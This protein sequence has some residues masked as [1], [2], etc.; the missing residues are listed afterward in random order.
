MRLYTGLKIFH[1]QNKLDS[2]PQDQPT[3]LPPIH[4]RIKPTNACNHNCSYC[5]YRADNL[6]L[7]QHMNIR[8]R[9]P[10]AK[11]A[12]IVEDCVALGVKAVT[13][14]GGGEPLC[15]PHIVK[16]ANALADGGVGIAT[17]TN[18]AL[19]QGAAADVF[20][21]RGVWVRL[22]MDGWDGPSYARYRNVPETEFARVMDNIEAFQK[23]GGPCFLGVSFIVGQD[24]ADHV[25]E[26][27]RRLKDAGVASLK[28]SPCV[29]SND[30]RENNA[31]H[32]PIFDKVK[33]QTARA[34]AELADEGF[35][36]FDSYHRLD[37][38]FTKSYSWC[39]YL[40]I[41]PVI[42]A[43]QRVYSCQDKAY[44]LDCG[45]LGSIRDRRFADFWR[46][47]K[48]KFFAINPAR[49]CNHH[50]VANGKNRL[51]HE[52]LDADPR[53]LPFV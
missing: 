43:D 34:A 25:F 13:F 41:L 53:H 28:Y 8:D 10:E 22:S 19:L 50:C 15:Y 44:N 39:P 51:V 37:E 18:G 52:Y 9:I 30:G 48:D 45:L 2:L 20:A 12:E 36:I 24:N 23:R 17:L 7:G 35:E 1:Y 31:Y 14:S 42:A 11:M 49:D 38:K 16:T 4:I 3:I 33:E 40:Q 47:G 5:A 6:Q 26:M 32:R 27:G 46:D 21:H 29:V